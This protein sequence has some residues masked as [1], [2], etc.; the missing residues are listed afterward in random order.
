METKT[1]LRAARIGVMALVAL[2]SSLSGTVGTLT[3]VRDGKA[4]TIAY[5]ES[6]WPFSFLDPA[7]RLVGYAVDLYLKIADGICR[8]LTLSHLHVTYAM[9]TSRPRISAITEGKAD[10]ECG[11]MTNTAERRRLAAPGLV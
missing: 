1:F 5:R 6:S 9:V 11:S 7:R 8:D 2:L 4:I 3:K 10:F